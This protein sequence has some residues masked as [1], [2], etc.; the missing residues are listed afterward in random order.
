MKYK[1]KITSN[2]IIF[3]Y[4]LNIYFLRNNLNFLKKGKNVEKIYRIEYY[5]INIKFL[6]RN[7]TNVKKS[8]IRLC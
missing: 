7:I 5:I 1:Y 4:I 2:Y 8:I 6:W 3:Y